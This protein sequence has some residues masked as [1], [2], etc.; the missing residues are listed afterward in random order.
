MAII[1]KSQIIYTKRY[2]IKHHWKT[3]HQLLLSPIH[4]LK[5]FR[6]GRQNGSSDK[7]AYNLLINRRWTAGCLKNLTPLTSAGSVKHAKSAINPSASSSWITSINAKDVWGPYVNN[8]EKLNVMFTKLVWS[9]T[10]IASAP[11]VLSNQIS[12]STLSDPINLNLVRTA[13]SLKSG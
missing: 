10:H 6:R 8:V 11:F 5:E 9:K 7:Y 3:S 2:N 12:W 1:N 13:L 4:S